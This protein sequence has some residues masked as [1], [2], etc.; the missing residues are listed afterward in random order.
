MVLKKAKSNRKKLVWLPDKKYD[1]G[2]P[3]LG[4]FQMLF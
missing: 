3:L 4:I 1:K 2:F